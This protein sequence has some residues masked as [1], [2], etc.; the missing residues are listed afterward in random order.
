MEKITIPKGDKGFNIAFTVKDSDGN[1]YVLTD[2]TITLKVWVQGAPATLLL[3]GACVI[4]DANLGTCHYVVA[5]G[6]FDTVGR[7][8]AEVELT[9]TGVVEST[10][11]FEIIVEVSG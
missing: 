9:K 1:A 10:Q 3:S 8:H 2:Y 7:Y 11:T 4:D 6:A 5:A